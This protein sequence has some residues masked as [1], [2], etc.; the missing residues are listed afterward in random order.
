[1]GRRRK[2]NRQASNPEIPPG[3]FQSA[4]I[5]RAP[6]R[7]S[8]LLSPT[9]Y[10][11]QVSQDSDPRHIAV[12]VAGTST[13]SQCLSADETA[14][15]DFASSAPQV[16]AQGK[17]AMAAKDYDRAAAL[18]TKAAGQ[19]DPASRR[20][21]EELLGVAHE[22]AGQLAHA[23]AEYQTY[24]KLHPQGADAARVRQRLDG[25]L[26][27]ID[28]EA[29]RQF[30]ESKSGQPTSALES[31]TDL[32]DRDLLSGA[33]AAINANRQAAGPE[34][35][36]T[37]GW[38][39]ETSGSAGQFYYRDDGFTGLRHGTYDTHEVYQNELVSSADIIIH[40]ENQRS[41]MKVRIS[42][43]E[44]NGFGSGG[45]G[46]RTSIATAYAD[47]R[48]KVSGLQARLGRQSRSGG[49]VFGRFDG[50]LFGIEVDDTYLLQAV[51]GSPVY[52]KS[53]EP[54][55]D[56]RY[57][58]GASLD[59]KLAGN[60]VS[61]SVY[62]IEQDIK[63][64]IDRRALGAELR[65]A[66]G[67]VTGYSALDYDIYYNEINAAYVSGSW[68]A[69]P[70]LSVYGTLD[71]R[72]VPFLL[73]SNALMGQQVDTLASLVELFGLDETEAL[74]VDRT[75]SAATAS[76]GA[77][78]ELTEAWQVALDA[79]IA[80]YTGTPASG[81]VDVIPDPGMEHYFSAQLNGNGILTENDY[82]GLGLRFLDNESYRTYIADLSLR[83]PIND[84]LRINPRV[85]MAY[86]DGSPDYRQLMILPSIGLKYAVSDHWSLETE[87]GFRWEDNTIGASH[88]RNG[89]LLFT[90]GYRYEF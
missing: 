27:A 86:R 46:D 1:M 12:T 82:V 81:G 38:S 39:W 21:A 43:Y 50:G 89:E 68:A 67:D 88:N 15:T 14:K 87:I 74:A 85:L 77:S 47:M 5:P 54:F 61:G 2:K 64:L 32:P 44:E 53:V 33:S 19:G 56:G 84:D 24:L 76:A 62:A 4:T 40:G 13:I 20:E 36:K 57:F 34:V 41:E 75:A 42:G 28:A 71:Y 26:A 6:V 80:N 58:Y 11:F 63:S 22:S 52:Y 48:D 37:D 31:K 29:N 65:Y 45:G 78:Y 90:A 30:A 70:G 35:Q 51:V 25:V 66:K 73:T 79:S 60:S 17:K 72:H 59:M 55:A 18:F 23:K 49:G 83:Y 69:T 9:T 10:I 16:L 3:W 8:C 7:S